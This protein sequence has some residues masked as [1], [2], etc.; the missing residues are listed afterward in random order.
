VGPVRCARPT[1]A[2]GVLVMDETPVTVS[3]ETS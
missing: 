3:K 2:L 1:P